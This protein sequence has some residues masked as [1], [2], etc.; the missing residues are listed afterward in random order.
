[1]NPMSGWLLTIRYLILGALIIAVI[2]DAR[3]EG[4]SCLIWAA[5][6]IGGLA[7]WGLA[8]ETRWRILAGVIGGAITGT[9]FLVVH[10]TPFLAETSV[11][12]RL[13]FENAMVGGLLGLV[14]GFLAGE[15]ASALASPPRLVFKITDLLLL[16]AAAAV[17]SGGGLYCLRLPGPERNLS[18][19][20]AILVGIP[21]LVALDSRRGLT[22]G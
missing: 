15:T 13:G 19:V 10:E 16:V 11:A 7:G 9:V 1:M 2:C 21:I 17:I 6:L 18:L 20:L 5:P 22:V 14:I 3:W 4:W 12:L 8:T